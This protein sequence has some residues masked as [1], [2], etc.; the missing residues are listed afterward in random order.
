MVTRPGSETLDD[1][2]NAHAAAD[3]ERGEAVALLAALELVD[4]G[5]ED[6][7]G[8][9]AEWVARRD[10]P[11]VDVDLVRGQVE[12]L[13]EPQDDGRER[14]VDLDE[15]EVVDGQPGLLQRLA[16]R[17]RRTGQH[18]GRLLAGHRGGQDAGPRREAELLADRLVADQQRGGAVDDA[19]AV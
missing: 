17:G 16:G 10:G 3:A 18:D 6:H 7:A 8:G 5:A 2:R 13:H 11:T 19:G 12:V 15:V 4:E 1:G 14:L 9:R